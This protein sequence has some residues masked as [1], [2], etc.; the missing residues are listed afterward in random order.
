MPRIPNVQIIPMDLVDMLDEHQV[1][2][3][4]G[5]IVVEVRN[6]RGNTRPDV[7][8]L[9]LRPSAEFVG[10]DLARLLQNL[11]LNGAVRARG[12]RPG[13][14]IT[15]VRYAMLTNFRVVFAWVRACT[16]DVQARKRV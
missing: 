11:P 8:R 16:L 3:Y 2:F 5:C 15:R 13:P 10:A 4:E 6:H 14:A 1:H 9:L 12:P 7:R